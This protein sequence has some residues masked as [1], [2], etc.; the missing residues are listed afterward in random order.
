MGV[1]VTFGAHFTV[2]TP[3]V[4]CVWVFILPL[5][6]V[7]PYGQLGEDASRH[8]FRY[9]SMRCLK[10]SIS[11]SGLRVCRRTTS[12]PPPRTVYLVAHMASLLHGN[13][14]PAGS[15]IFADRPPVQP[16]CGPLSGG[17]SPFPGPAIFINGASQ[18]DPFDPAA[19]L[20]AP[21]EGAVSPTM[22][23]LAAIST[24]PHATRHRPPPCHQRLENTSE[25]AGARVL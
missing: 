14:D 1:A 9:V 23:P 2:P 11:V 25:M 15:L 18:A 3:A 12:P 4:P 17:L 6:T 7:S 10:A 13:T 8:H 19:R 16:G 5:T 24:L 20:R 22:R 21:W